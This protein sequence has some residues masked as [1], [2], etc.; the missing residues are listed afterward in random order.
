MVYA[1]SFQVKHVLFG[2]DKQVMSLA[3][4]ATTT[5]NIEQVRNT[6]LISYH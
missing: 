2:Q 4:T 6:L 3:R 1:I 5:T